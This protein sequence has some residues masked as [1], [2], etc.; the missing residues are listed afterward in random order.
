MWTLYIKEPTFSPHILSLPMS[1]QFTSSAQAWKF[2]GSAPWFT[3]TDTN[4]TNGEITPS[5]CSFA[6]VHF[7]L[8]DVLPVENQFQFDHTVQSH[9]SILGQLIQTT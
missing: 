6:S 1:L 7:I 2:W 3:N 4:Y 8:L 9:I 5:T